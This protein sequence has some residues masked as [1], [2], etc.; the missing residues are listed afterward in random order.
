[1]DAMQTLVVKLVEKPDNDT[2]LEDELSTQM[3]ALCGVAVRVM[4]VAATEGRP[5]PLAVMAASE[6]ARTVACAMLEDYG[7]QVVSARTHP[8]AELPVIWTA[9]GPTRDPAYPDGEWWAWLDRVA[10]AAIRKAA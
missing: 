6:D 2:E 7:Y 4:G 3:A 5:V 1:M 10:T 8:P 9:T